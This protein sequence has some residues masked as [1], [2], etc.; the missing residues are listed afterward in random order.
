MAHKLC[1]NI[2]SC[3]PLLTHSKCLHYIITGEFD[4]HLLDDREYPCQ[5][6]LLTPYLDPE[7]NSILMWPTAGLEPMLRLGMLK[8]RFQ[9][10]RRLRVT[11]ERACDLIV[12]CVFL[13]NIATIRGEPRNDPEED[14]PTDVQDG[15]AVREI[16]YQNHFAD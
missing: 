3:R 1:A 11:P 12:A 13:H 6:S 15:R 14:H 5:P 8:A 7:L 16:I 2:I 10:I 4:S 9:C